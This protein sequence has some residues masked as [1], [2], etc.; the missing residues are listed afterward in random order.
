MARLRERQR[1]QRTEQV[2][3]AAATLFAERGYNGTHVE[4]IAERAALAPATVYKYFSTKP[5]ILLALAVRHVRSALPERRRLLRNPPEDPRAAVQA[6]EELLADQALRHIPKDCWRIILSAPFIE[7]GG[8]AARTA[9][10]LGSLIRRHYLHLFAFYQQRGLL[11]KNVDAAAL[12]DLMLVI[13]TEH[14]ARLVTSDTLT[15]AD[16]KRAAARHIDIVF[17]GLIAGK[18]RNRRQ[19]RHAMKERSR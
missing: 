9:L 6:Y 17:N 19:D 4:A 11:R 12:A 3:E 14:L 2:L 15:L 5:N 8:A 16:Q 7:P 18:K 10:R 13:G 1:R